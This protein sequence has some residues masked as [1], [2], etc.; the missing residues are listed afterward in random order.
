MKRR[1]TAT[2]AAVLSVLTR[3]RRAMSQDA[4]LH[5]LDVDVN[6]ATVYRILNR[7]CEDEIVHRI[8]ADD[9]KQYFAVCGKG[10]EATVPQDHF[11]FRCTRCE[12][13]EC[14]PSTVHYSLPE[15]YEVE[16]L[17]CVLVGVCKDCS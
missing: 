5:Q 12:T 13:I 4:I 8:V 3:R 9:G 7:F 17:N 15:G 11:H 16:N 1:N 6:R 2:Q 14:L 10:D